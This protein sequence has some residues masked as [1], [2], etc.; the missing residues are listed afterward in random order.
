[1]GALGEAVGWLDGNDTAEKEEFEHRQKEVEVCAPVLAKV[2][3]GGEGGH[4]PGA[5]GWAYAW[6]WGQGTHH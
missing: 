4:M 2:Y 5:G 3:A 6:C 1:M